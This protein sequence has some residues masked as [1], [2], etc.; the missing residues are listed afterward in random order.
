MRQFNHPNILS[1][2]GISVHEDKPCVILPLMS[3]GDLEKYLRKHDEVKCFNKV[4][5]SQKFMPK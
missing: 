5:E 4:K 3:N 1:I 2:C